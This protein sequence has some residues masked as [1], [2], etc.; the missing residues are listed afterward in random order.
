MRTLYKVINFS[1]IALML[2]LAFTGCRESAPLE[3][4][5]IEQDT[6]FTFSPSHGYPG[7]AVRLTGEVLNGVLEVSFGSTSAEI[8]SS[9]EGVINAQV[10]V[11]AST[12]K[13]RLVKENSVISSLIPFVVDDTPIPTVMS[14]NPAIAGSGDI[15]TITG[16]LLD[17]VDSVHIGDAK[18]HLQGGGSTSS[19][20]IK[21][22]SFETGFISLFYNY[23]TSY[24]VSKVGESKSETE[25]TLELPII[26][27]ITPDISALDI[28]DVLT[29]T[30]T[31]MDEID[32]VLFQDV[33]AEFSSVSATE[34]N[35]TV[36]TG[37]TT[38]K[39]TLYVTDGN[40]ESS[41]DFVI[42]LPSI[43]S[44]VPDKGEFL[45]AGS[46]RI[47]SVQGKNLSLVTSVSLGEDACTIS[48]QTDEVIIF[49]A[50][51][52]Y[53][54]FISLHTENG[55]VLSSVPF[56]LAGDFWVNDWDNTYDPV[57]WATDVFDEV[58]NPAITT[59]AGGPTGNYRKYV[60]EVKPGGGSLARIYWR[61]DDNKFTMYT[62]SPKDM[63]LE[64]DM[65]YSSVPASFINEDGSMDIHMF[66]FTA[67]RTPYGF[68]IDV[69][70]P[71]T[72]ADDW[73]HVVVVLS[74]M[75]V[76]ENLHNGI[77]EAG[78][79]AGTI[80]MDDLRILC[81][82]FPASMDSNISGES[83]NVNF[84]NIKFKIQ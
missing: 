80:L 8:L 58:N 38:G 73:Q 81:P 43:T 23:M 75:T 39:I 12:G 67:S 36:P 5:P 9:S 56:F 1:F 27:S 51:A 25:L 61:D 42:N 48:S 44:F 55:T 50:D 20:Q 57:R 60:G 77:V 66:L 70:I 24:G 11:G 72:G 26:S 78:T 34:M 49:I 47:F 41:K 83:I 74:D 82:T 10:P 59:E 29:V 52:T 79:P 54:G 53:K 84:D 32:S 76:D 4:D 37:V 15:V 17:M 18:A 30:G 63:T 22:P 13:I 33:E 69:N 3:I 40:T 7:T 6:L 35:V 46:E 21:L 68:S 64:F 16:S 31:M 65:S 14:F 2:F 71:F 19:I 45:P 62:S 28:G